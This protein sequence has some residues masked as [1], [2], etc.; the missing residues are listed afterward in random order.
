MSA[1]QTKHP[2]SKRLS[3]LSRKLSYWL[4]HRPQAIGIQLDAQGWVP[5]SHLLE[6]ANAHGHAIDEAAVL[7]VVE[8]DEKTRYALDASQQKIRANQG[9]SVAVDLKLANKVPPVVLY[10]GTP[11][12]NLASI[13]KQGLLPQSRHAVHLSAL[14]DTARVVGQ[15]RG[16][17]VVLKVDAKA[18]LA[19]GFVFQCADNG[20]WLTAH[21]PPKYLSQGA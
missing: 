11:T 21:V 5:I 1:H 19:A 17:A 10:H 9:H 4:R 16:E 14:Q 3:E 7:A 13:L 2:S 8:Q 12:K 20:V 15:R 6:H 18:M